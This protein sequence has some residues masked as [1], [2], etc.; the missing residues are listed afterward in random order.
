MI[1][2]KDAAIEYEQLKIKEREIKERLEILHPIVSTFIPE[3]QNVQMKEGYFYIQMRKTWKFS[4]TATQA[5]KNLK[6]M[7][8][9]EKADGTATAKEEPTLYYRSG[10]PEE[11]EIKE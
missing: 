3:G 9:S 1:D 2:P 10:T 6:T 4:E 5:K 11:H 8:E 7:E